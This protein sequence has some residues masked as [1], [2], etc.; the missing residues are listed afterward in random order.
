MTN[1]Q[2]HQELVRQIENLIQKG[3]PE[4][5]GKTKTEFKEMLM[6]LNEKLPVQ[7]P[8]IDLENG[9]LPFVIVIK[10]ELISAEKMME[11]V[12][13]KDKEGITKLFPH[14]STDFSVIDTV[15]L[16]QDS[17]Y[18]LINIDRGKETLNVRPEDAFKMIESQN[19][20]PLTIDEGIALVTHFPDFLIK[21]NC[22]SLLAS[23]HKGDQ[24]V[25]AIWINAKK[26]P[27]LGW[28][29]DRNPHTWLGSA[30]AE[31]RIG[32]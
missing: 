32:N 21:N 13:L 20:T 22:F 29:W 3:Y 2:Y 28:C 10:N 30:S 19:R 8:E 25:P 11:K 7:L 4:L 17:V 31:Q 27:N 9:K 18:L 12:S 5:M 26:H 24:R 14:T 15:V 23:R 6:S 16:P 1:S